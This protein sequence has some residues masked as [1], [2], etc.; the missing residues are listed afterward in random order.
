[1][2]KTLIS[3]VIASAILFGVSMYSIVYVNDTFAF[4][5]RALLS[6]YDKTEAQTAT[7]E[8]GTAVQRFWE[9]KK[10]SLHVWVPHTAI[11][12][13]DYQLYEAVGFLY[14]QDYKAALPKI[15]VV[16]GM[17]EN[18]PHSYTLGVENIF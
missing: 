13:V 5:E 17:C 11:Q 7:Y 12:E 3:I 6:L 14:V 1:M 8:D 15:E 2:V 16:L 4:F 10:K 18:I 9:E